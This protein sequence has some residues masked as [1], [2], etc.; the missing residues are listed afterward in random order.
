MEE[1]LV[2]YLLEALDADT[3]Q[4]VEAS[5]LTS[6]QLRTRL[7]LLERALKPLAADADNPAPRPGLVLSTLALVAEHQC[8]KLP[9]APLPPR[10]QAMPSHRPWM[11]RPDVLVAALLLIVLGGLG[12]SALVHLWRDYN[13]RVACQRNLHLVWG[14]LQQYCDTHQGNFPRVEEKGPRGVAG[15]FVP[16]L[17]DNGLL[18][19]EASLM[20]PPQG[21]GAPKCR[22]VHELEEL[23][24]ERPREFLAE[25]HQLAGGYAYTLGYR[26]AFGHHGLR[27]DTGEKDKLPIMADRLDSLNQSNSA[28]HGGN[29]QNVLYLG[30][31]VQWHTNRNAGI[32]GDDIFTNWDN[33]VLAGKAREDTVLG[34]SDSSPTPRE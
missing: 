34:P 8:L 33:K 23:Y 1:N 6:P 20:C 26:D 25:A 9:S 11:R 29:G 31:N 30:G 4:Q 17:C 16:I 3:R 15:I 24:Q 18:S 19:P 12:S 22:S 14:G 27:C 13:N 7:A 10:D 2:G 28:N 32:K 5:L 21:H